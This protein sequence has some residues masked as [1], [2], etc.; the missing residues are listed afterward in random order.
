MNAPA[1]PKQN[2]CILYG[3]LK[4]STPPE[5]EARRNG[6]EDDQTAAMVAFLDFWESAL[7]SRGA[8]Y[9]KSLGD[10]FLATFPDP[11][12]GLRAVVEAWQHWIRLPAPRPPLRLGM[13]CGMVAVR[14]DGDIIGPDAAFGKRVETAAGADQLFVS[15]AFAGLVR[16][17]L[18][19]GYALHDAGILPL[20]GFRHPARLFAL[21][22]PGLE[23]PAESCRLPASSTNLTQALDKFI[24]RKRERKEL[25][26]LL[27]RASEP[28]ITLL[29]PGGCGKTR[30]A[31]QVGWDVLGDFPQG[32]YF[33]SV[34]NT[35]SAE[36]ILLRIAEAVGLPLSPNASVLYN[37]RQ[38]LVGRRLLI[39]DNFD[40]VTAY[41]ADTV[42][43]LMRGL[44]ELRLLATSRD[45]LHCSGERCYDLE[46]LP[47]P[48]T[49]ATLRQIGASESVKLFLE[50]ARAADRH[51][52]CLTDTIAPHVALLCRTLSGLPLALELVAAEVRYRPLS[53]L[54][55]DV[56]S[57]LL[58]IESRRP[59]LPPR[60][61]SLR[62][63]FDS[64][65]T[66][67]DAPDRSLFAQLG[68]FGAAFSENDV[69]D[70]CTGGD[71]AA[72][73]RRLQNR[74]LLEYDISDSER[75]Y[76]L[77]SPLREYARNALSEHDGPARR[78]FLRA[79]LRRAQSLQEKFIHQGE[80]EALRGIQADLENFRAAWSMAQSENDRKAV[81]DMGLAVTYFVPLLPRSANLDDWIGETE[82]ALRHLLSECRDEKEKREIMRHLARVCNTE[83]RL[84]RSR[85]DLMVAVA[86]QRRSLVWSQSVG[87]LTEI[88]DAHSTLA[89][90]AE[91]AG[92]YDTAEKHAK[93]GIEVSR[94]AGEQEPEAVALCVLAS[95]FIEKDIALAVQY[96]EESLRLFREMNE[97]LGMSNA[98]MALAEIAEKQQDLRAAE[99]HYREALRCR[100]LIRLDVSL[101][102]LLEILAKFYG[103]TGRH[104]F[105]DELLLAAA[106]AQRAMGLRETASLALPAK[107]HSP[108][109]LRPLP[110]A[111]AVERALAAPA[112]IS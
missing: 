23:A 13:H 94:Q 52:P 18:P 47:V 4:D 29:G 101:V 34:E 63:A 86:H 31:Q 26:R 85:E 25:R 60:Q 10:G 79:F 92:D 84:A 68:M 75:P 30:L 110:L 28:C 106:E 93:E 99:T 108:L 38:V 58:E 16:A 66:R 61:R 36:A 15:E 21:S 42:V 109:P 19:D 104:D 64:S 55:E 102:R 78:R 76:R 22:A 20:K 46:P 53:A 50:R 43:P 103:R 54:C 12:P 2:L 33:V 74:S 49:D 95:V 6:A 45:P 88:A 77:L 97:Q 35:V 37:L 7:R 72:G 14:P 73:L 67:L 82:R 80:P 8:A 11:V 41:A 32:V 87:T 17:Y 65:F 105:A 81:A 9:F 44:P 39:L 5:E 112:L 70:V 91:L 62:A 51:F 59:D 96:A 98:Y 27:L 69:V 71:L 111:E 90:F 24:G 48:P 56:R 40:A 89:H 57:R 83:A 100:A 107:R 1:L 3:D